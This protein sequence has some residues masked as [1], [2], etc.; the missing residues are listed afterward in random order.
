MLG[1]AAPAYQKESATPHSGACMHS[2]QYDGRPDWCFGMWVGSWNLCSL[3]GKGE[4][5]DED[6]MLGMKRR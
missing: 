4:V 5:C 1:W 6:G 3:C 2:L